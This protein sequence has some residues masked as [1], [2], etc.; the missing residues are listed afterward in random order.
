MDELK[1]VEV[2]EACIREFQQSADHFHRAAVAM[3][4]YIGDLQAQVIR[5]KREQIAKEKVRENV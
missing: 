3:D 2:L 5:L 1:R 4:F